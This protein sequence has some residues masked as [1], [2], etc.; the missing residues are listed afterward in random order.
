[1][2]VEFLGIPRERAG[3]SELELEAGTLGQALDALAARFPRLGELVTAGRLHP[4]LAVSLNT[5][6][7]ISDPATPLA[8]EDR[9]LILSADA[10]G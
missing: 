8:R 9:L 5:N 3:L 7:F 2:H 1:M 10:G 4:S 6:E